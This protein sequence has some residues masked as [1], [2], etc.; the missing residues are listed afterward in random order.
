MFRKVLYSLTLLSISII[1]LVGCSNSQNKQNANENKEIQSQ[2]DTK[3]IDSSKDTSN[4]IVSD[5]IDKPSK[6]ATNNDNNK[7]DVSSLDNTALD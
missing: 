2:E 3:K 4:V 1:F 7:L 6:N 5:G